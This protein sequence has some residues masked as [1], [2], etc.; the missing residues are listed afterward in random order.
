MVL[1]APGPVEEITLKDE[2]LMMEGKLVLARTEC[3]DYRM[4]RVAG[5]HTTVSADPTGRRGH[6]NLF[7]KLAKCLKEAGA[8]APH[9]EGEDAEGTR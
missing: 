7:G 1:N 6:P 4:R 8:P 5:L 2:C 9:V 3:L